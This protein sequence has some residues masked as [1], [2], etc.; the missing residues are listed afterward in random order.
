MVTEPKE[1]FLKSGGHR[2]HYLLWGGSGPKLVFLH[3]MGMDARGFDMI[4][5]ALTEEYQVLALDILDHG[6][7]DTPKE[8]VSLRDHA[9]IM[10]DC[11]R[12]LGFYPNV[13]VGHSV[14]G[15]MGMV[16]AAEHPEDLRGLV[17]VDI[18]PFEITGR[19][20][21]PPPPEYFADVE[22]ARRYFRERYPGF[23]PEAV[24]N[25]VRYALAKNEKGRLKLKPTGAAI[26]PGLATN[27]WPYAE[28]MRTPT[29]MILGGESTLV[30]EET[31]KRM[32]R[33]LPDLNVVT[34]K[35]ATHMVPQ[36]KPDEFEGHLRAFL[37]GLSS[38]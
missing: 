14:G 25:R 28:R 11:Y 9:E 18:A 10:R 35:G 13:L 38:S 32:K 31:I 26:R 21:R 23:K 27:L 19:S 2:I 15:M 30:T 3:S 6:D 33:T 34:V 4:S 37:E 5:G 36:D 16:L 12:Q 24:E 7:S 8:S 20:A 1:G 22:E 17:L 29:L